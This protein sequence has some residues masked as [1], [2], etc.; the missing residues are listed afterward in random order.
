MLFF[1]H[2]PELIRIIMT[3][4]ASATARVLSLAVL[5]LSLAPLG[6]MY[7]LLL[8]FDYKYPD[9]STFVSTGLDAA[10]DHTQGAHSLAQVFKD[11]NA[12]MEEL[13]TALFLERRNPSFISSPL[14]LEYLNYKGK[15]VHHW[16][17]VLPWLFSFILGVVVPTVMSIY[18]VLCQ[19][20]R[21]RR[22]DGPADRERRLVRIRKKVKHYTKTLVE[23]DLASDSENDEQ[24]EDVTPTWKLPPPG[25][26]LPAA[27]AA[28]DTMPDAS[29]TP[30]V[31][32]RPVPG[33]CAICLNQ[34]VIDE[35]IIWSPN[36]D[37]VHCFHEDCIMPW[38]MRKSSKHRQC[39]CC[40][41]SFVS[42]T[43]TTTTVKAVPTTNIAVA[44]AEGTT[45]GQSS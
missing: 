8:S 14:L 43:A 34:Y 10:A 24:D 1:I 36:R 9:G 38:L 11:P 6:S 13:W 26:T 18:Y 31:E 28:A 33:T 22:G 44:P 32:T 3:A 16:S 42:S 27:I 41:Q 17:L 29:E 39:P 20:R 5:L 45:T 35:V 40:R 19:R 15:S 23:E 30:L 4:S 7:V 2:I 12:T 37:C 21:L 25:V